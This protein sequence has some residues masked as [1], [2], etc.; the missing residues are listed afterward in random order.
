MQSAKF[1]R[2]S[3]AYQAQ[4]EAGS[5]QPIEK[6]LRAAAQAC[7]VVSCLSLHV[8]AQAELCHLALCQFGL[9]NDGMA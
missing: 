9:P 8:K 7:H 2:P 4:H 6:R 3:S 1:L 5:P